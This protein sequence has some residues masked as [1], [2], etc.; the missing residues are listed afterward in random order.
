MTGNDKTVPPLITDSYM[1][2]FCQVVEIPAQPGVNLMQDDIY[3]KQEGAYCVLPVRDLAMV[4][5]ISDIN[6]KTA[7]MPTELTSTLFNPSCTLL[8][9]G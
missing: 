4:T 2:L 9:N 6:I 7:A 3:Q 5:S 1:H 8:I